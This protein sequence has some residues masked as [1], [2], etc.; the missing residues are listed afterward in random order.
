M[1][2]RQLCFY[3]S[4]SLSC[5]LAPQQQQRSLLHLRTAHMHYYY[6]SCSPCPRVLDNNNN[7]N[8]NCYHLAFAFMLPFHG[9]SSVML[10]FSFLAFSYKKTISCP[11]RYSFGNNNCYCLAI[12][13]LSCYPFTTTTITFIILLLP[14]FCLLAALSQQQ[15]QRSSSC[16]RLAFAFLLPFNGFNIILL[17]R[18]LLSKTQTHTHINNIYSQLCLFSSCS[19]SL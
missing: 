4:S 1:D 13:S 17:P 19:A 14:R 18:S 15:Q 5:S 11:S 2:V 10:L 3:S 16:Y 9:C 6:Y 8:N 7:N 12:V